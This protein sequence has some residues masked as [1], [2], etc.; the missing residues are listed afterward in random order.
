VNEKSSVV[1]RSVFAPGIVSGSALKGNAR[2]VS[3][4]RVLSVT[5]LLA[6]RPASL[7]FWDRSIKG[8]TPITTPRK[9]AAAIRV[10]MREKP[11]SALGKGAHASN[12]GG[13]EGGF[14]LMPRSESKIGASFRKPRFFSSIPR[15]TLDFSFCPAGFKRG[16]SKL[17]R[18]FW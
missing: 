10:S 14:H 3:R 6:I 16:F 12:D 9:R 18:Y 5:I 8:K 1:T 4:I 2:W 15:K 13:E 11:L 7:F 17:I